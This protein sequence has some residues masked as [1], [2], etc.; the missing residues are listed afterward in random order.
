[1]KLNEKDKIVAVKQYGAKAIGKKSLLKHL[2]GE[3]IGRGAA[4][5]AK[6]YECMGFYAD[7]KVSCLIPSCPLYGFMPYRHIPAIEISERRPGGKR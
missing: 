4:I 6:C 3:K 1:M 7:G 5:R 2:R